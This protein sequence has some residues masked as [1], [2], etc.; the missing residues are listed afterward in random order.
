MP[1]CFL[2][3]NSKDAME[4]LVEKKPSENQNCVSLRACTINK[5]NQTALAKDEKLKQYMKH[6]A[7]EQIVKE[8][9]SAEQNYSSCKLKIRLICEIR[10]DISFQVW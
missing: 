10:A 8:S 6:K 4:A 2:I 9:S 5:R 1:V 7:T 3:E